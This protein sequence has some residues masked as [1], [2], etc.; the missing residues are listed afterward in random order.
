ML[1]NCCQWPKILLYFWISSS[2]IEAIILQRRS[3]II[4]SLIFIIQTQQWRKRRLKTWLDRFQWK[5][6]KWCNLQALNQFP[7][8]TERTSK[9]RLSMLWTIADWTL[10][11][12]NWRLLLVPLERMC[13]GEIIQPEDWANK[14]FNSA[15]FVAIGS[16]VLS[17]PV[18]LL[19]AFSF[20]ATIIFCVAQCRKS[21]TIIGT[22]PRAV[23]IQI[24][25]DRNRQ[26][27]TFRWFLYSSS[28]SHGWSSSWCSCWLEP[29]RRSNLGVEL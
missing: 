12:Y 8:C 15:L 23:L 1:H 10:G 22:Q 2:Y 19:V 17:G 6:D 24:C 16:G 27:V 5:M 3:A 28:S 9:M 21:F 4:L 18:C 13:Y 25:R 11:R 7:S 14:P 29:L 20:W 26:L